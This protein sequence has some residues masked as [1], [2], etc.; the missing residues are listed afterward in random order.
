MDPSPVIV[1]N[2]TTISNP[3]LCF[4]RNG[5]TPQRTTWTASSLLVPS[6]NPLIPLK[7]SKTQKQKLFYFE[8]LK[9][10]GTEGPPILKIFKNP[11]LIKELAN[12]ASNFKPVFGMYAPGFLFSSFV[13]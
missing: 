1:K 9:N 11:K 5:R 7:S 3:E 12:T 6:Q 10:S 2:N 13:K 8:K 4:L